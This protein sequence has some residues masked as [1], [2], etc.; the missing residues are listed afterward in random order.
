MEK[1][2]LK[3]NEVKIENYNPS[4]PKYFSEEARSIFAVL[5][6][7][8]TTI[9]HVGSTAVTGMVAKPIIDILLG[10][11]RYNDYLKL[12]KP[13]RKIGY[14][15]YREPRRYQALFL[16]KSPDGLT[17]HHLKVVKYQGKH[18]W[19]YI[20]FRD[21]LRIDKRLFNSYKKL[22][23]NLLTNTTLDRK[24]YTA[25]KVNFIKNCLV[26]T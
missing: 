14:E 5:D 8:N 23:L 12:I 15:F 22:K 4:W 10:V 16:K 9:E 25:G 2:G 19:K 21:S 7:H 20:K 17:T 1:L 13:L 11:E 3:R 26:E 6:A 18:W 24:M